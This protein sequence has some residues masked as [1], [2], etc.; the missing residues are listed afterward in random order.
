M[1]ATFITCVCLNRIAFIFDSAVS[2]CFQ[3]PVL[4][5][6]WTSESLKHFASYSVVFIS[7]HQHCYCV[8]GSCLT[9]CVLFLLCLKALFSSLIT[10][11]WQPGALKSRQGAKFSQAVSLDFQ[12]KLH[13]E[14]AVD[15]TASVKKHSSVFFHMCTSFALAKPSISKCGV[16]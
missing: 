15:N 6:D 10:G 9:C 2:Q 14:G 5:L 1:N 4:L 12:S 11:F 13:K 7:G 3:S 8:H 16:N